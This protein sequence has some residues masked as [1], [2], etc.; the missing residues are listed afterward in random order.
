MR[1]VPVSDAHDLL[2]NLTDGKGFTGMGLNIPPIAPVP[3]TVSFNIEWNGIIS[4]SKIVNEMQT[5]RGH[6]VRTGATIDWS[7]APSKQ[8]G[9]AFQSET[10]NPARNRYSVIGHEQNG[11]FFHPEDDD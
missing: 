7:A 5:F 6:F 10:P 8:G 2:N 1:D 11:V 9:F 4:S 3:A